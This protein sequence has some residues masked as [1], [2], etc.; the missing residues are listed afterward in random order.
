[1]QD[2]TAGQPAR[3]ILEPPP[4]SVV[5]WRSRYGPRSK[6]YE[7]IGLHVE[8]RGWYVTGRRDRTFSFAEIVYW[9][10]RESPI[11]LVTDWG[12]A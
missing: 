11:Y 6:L 9:P 7:H 5:F 8:G 10:Q 3:A 1:M 2:A 4:H 12:L